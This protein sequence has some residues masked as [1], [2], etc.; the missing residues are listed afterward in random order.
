MKSQHPTR[1]R[2]VRRTRAASAALAAALSFQAATPVQAGGI[3]V[4]DAASLLDRAV[5]HAEVLAKYSEQIAMLKSQ[6]EEARRRYEAITGT[7][8]LGDILNNPDIRRALPEDV[9]AI[10]GHPTLDNDEVL[11]RTEEIVKEERTTGDYNKDLQ[12]LDK[13]SDDLA[14]RSKA[15]LQRAQSGTTARIKQL[16]QLQAQI[17]RATDPKAIA[18]LQARLL[19]EQA[20]I[21]ADQIRADLLSRQLQAE[22]DL[23]ALQAE[24]LASKSLSLDAIHAPIPRK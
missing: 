12:A 17:N 4:V 13:R 20:N 9:R 19:V 5:K 10:L 18:D 21:Q 11:R 3:P 22:R 2:Y 24:K 1:Q 23:I 16:D 15:L 14:Y 6:L 8:N 7:R